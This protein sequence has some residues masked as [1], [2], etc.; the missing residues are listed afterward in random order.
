MFDGNAYA[1]NSL[2]VY[3][4]D[5]DGLTFLEDLISHSQLRTE[6]HRAS[7]TD[8]FKLPEFTDNISIWK[9]IN[10]TQIYF[11]EVNRHTSQVDILRLIHDQLQPDK[12][13]KAAV[14]HLQER[15]SKHKSGNGMVLAEYRL[16][17]ITQTIMTLY[18]PKKRQALSQ[19]RQKLGM[20]ALTINAVDN[21]NA[22]DNI[23]ANRMTTQSQTRNGLNHANHHGEHRY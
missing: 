14:E 19:P 11:K 16:K 4:I 2:S 18:P 1:H 7:I 13:F 21:S 12:R 22:V 8:A 10:M 5:Q 6:V 20:T 17:S 3:A 9:Y 23:S 15:I